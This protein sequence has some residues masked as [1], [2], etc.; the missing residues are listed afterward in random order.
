MYGIP[1]A[2]VLAGSSALSIALQEPNPP[3]VHRTREARGI[4]HW[5]AIAANGYVVPAGESPL[6]L[7]LELSTHFG[8]PSS[9]LRDELGYG[10]S[11]AWIAR[12]QLLDDEERTSLAQAWSDNLHHGRDASR[13]DPDTRDHDVLLRSFS[14]LGLSLLAADDLQHPF[15]DREA[16]DT[17]LAEALDYLAAE[18]DLRGWVDELGWVH[19]TAHTADLLKFLAR[20]DKLTPQQQGEILHAIANRLAT[21]DGVVFVHGEQERLARAVIS[22]LAREDFEQAAFE[23]FLEALSRIN[24]RQAP[25]FDPELYAAAENVRQSMRCVIVSLDRAGELPERLRELRR[26]A[27]DA[28][29]RL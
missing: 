5:R 21:T 6:Q 12:A 9:E 27:V 7:L 13:E 25:E 23:S 28:M 16:F 29:G 2:L 18:T 3:I 24:G 22:L 4:E 26:L 8:S 19:A 1:C 17:L 11:A 14:A 10:I 15:L 20:N